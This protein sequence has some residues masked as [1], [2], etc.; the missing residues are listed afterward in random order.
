MQYLAI[1]IPL[2]FLSWFLVKLALKY[3]PRLG[4]LDRPHKYGLK[5]PPI[6]YYGGLV[7][8]IAFLISVLFWLPWDVRLVTFLGLSVLVAAVSFAD[9]SWGIRPL[10][11]LLLQVLVGAGLF[12][13]GIAVQALPNPF[14]AE[15]GLAGA[16]VGGVAVFSLLVTVFWVVLIMNALNWSDGIDGMTSGVGGL[17]ALVI[18]LLAARPNF[19]T[20]DQTAVLVMALSLFV[21]LAVFWRY[22]FPPAKI[23]MGDTGTMFVGFLLAGL[24]IY[25]GG[26]LATAVLVLGFPLLDAVWVVARRLLAGK[27]PFKG[28]LQHFHHRLLYAGLSKRQAVSVVYLL[29]CFFGMMA[30][31]LDSGSKVW[32]LIGMLAAMAVMGFLVVILEVEKSRKKD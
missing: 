21:V 14:G 2:L 4:F 29:S 30:L 1:A 11:R 6:P 19:H 22:E 26:K 9:D 32:A 8:V 27:S 28:D 15:I 10:Y 24:A 5:R 20:V 13:G 3:F 25:A 17:A 18:F 16:T 31:L 7:I 12:A 23:L